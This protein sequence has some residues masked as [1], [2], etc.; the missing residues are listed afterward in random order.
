MKS[1]KNRGVAVRGPDFP[2]REIR[3]FFPALQASDPFIFFDN[4]AGTQVPQVVLD[5]VHR[6]LID[7]NVQ[8][9]GRYRKSQEV[10]ALLAHARSSVADL[11]N[12][13]DPREISFGMNATS[14]IR[15]VSLAIGE[16][17][18]ERSE[19]VISNFDHEA[20]VST[21]LA[22]EKK[23]AKI[24]WWR[25]RN[26]GNLHIADLESLLSSRTRLVACTVASNATG[27]KVDVAGVAAMAH[28]YGAEVF[29]DCVHYGP[30]GTIDVQ[31]FGCDFLVCSGYK[32][33]APHMGFLW[34][35]RA[36][37]DRL[38]TF[39]EPFVPDE[40][41]SKIEVGTGIYE[42]I[43]G[44]D[45]AVSY[46]ESLGARLAGDD[47]HN[48]RRQNIVRATEA[49]GDYEES[50]SHELLRVLKGCGA[51]IYG[52]QDPA[53]LS[54]RVPTLLFNM[55]GVAAQQ[56]VEAMAG[57]GIGVRDGHMYA[58]RLMRE[59]GLNAETG[60]VRASLVHYSTAEE[61]H[62]FETVLQNMVR[63]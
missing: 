8:R 50:L 45:A 17:L 49:I 30:H 54:N 41:P 37:L 13:P 11:L 33:F 27:S 35:R 57:A 38:P 10:D 58:P 55:P 16:T 4:A 48:S 15:L 34:G 31:E 53:L 23:G 6:H 24:R 19:I 1:A 18:G 9:G 60:A 22:L 59:L 51:R 63:H 62:Q 52:I 12:A 46:L 21:W 26:D 47:G 56:V 61:I 39:R 32:I 44:M 42:N 14:F 28:S 43:A 25:V 40:A 5:A 2:V 7:R 29:L 20:N 36:I 3:S